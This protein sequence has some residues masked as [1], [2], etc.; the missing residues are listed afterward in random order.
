MTALRSRFRVERLEDRALPSAANY[1]PPSNFRV[2]SGLAAVDARLSAGA[3]LDIAL[4]YLNEH[5]GEFNATPADLIDP[6]VTGQ[7]TDADSGTTYIYLRQKVNGLEVVNAELSISI[8][9]SG[10]VFTVGG[11]FVAGLD[12]KVDGV[13]GAVMSAEQA[14]LAAA[15]E[16]S[17]PVEDAPTLVNPP[18][19][20]AQSF[21]VSAPSV[22]FHD[23]PAK[24]HYVPTADGGASL[25][26]NLIIETTDSQHWY[27]VSVDARTGSVVH[28]SDWIDHE[29]YHVVPSPND[30]PHDGG[31]QTLVNPQNPTA[32]PFGWHDTNGAVGAEFT[33][34]RG[35][36]VDAHL[37]RDADNVAD[38]NPP[39]PTGGAALD[40]G[41]YWFNATQAPSALANQNAAVV[42]LFHMNNLLHDVHY[43]YGFTEAAGNFQT[44]N[45]GKGGLGNDAVQADAQDGS[46]TNNANF[47]TPTD[48]N[49]P[50]MQMYIWTAANP[51]RDSDLDNGIIAHEY[52]HGVSNRLTGGP[53]NSSALNATQSGGMGEGWSDFHALM[54]AQRATDTKNGAFG[55]GTYVLNQ[56]VNGDGI[57]RFRYSFDMGVNPLTY[58]AYGSSGTTSYGVTRSN[59]VHNT[60][61]I[62]CST[63]W[64]LNWLL[65]DKYGFDPNLGTGWSTAAGPA[66]AGNKLTLKLVMDAM[67]LQP[68]NPSF[69]QARDA[70]IAA[71]IAVNG[72]ADLYEIWLAFARRGLGTNASTAGSSST[73]VS[74][75]FDLPM[76]VASVNPDTGAVVTSSPTGYT[77][78]VTSAINAASLQASDLTVNGQ[79]ATG[80]AYTPG[81]TFAVFT[82]ASD[83]VTAE[84]KQVIAV[85][86]NAF[87]RASDG[88]GVAAFSSSFYLDPTPL[89]V[90]SFTPAPGTT[91]SPPMTTLDINLNGA[92]N[93]ASIQVSDLSLSRGSVTGFSLLNGNTTVRF[94]LANLTTEG[95]VTASLAAGAFSDANG[96]PN[97]AFAG[98]S[99]ILDIGSSPFPVPLTARAPA[100]ALIYEGAGTALIGTAGDSDSLTLDLDAGQTLSV[101]VSPLYTLRPSLTI[102]GPGTNL[103]NTAAA[104]GAEARLLAVPISTAGT[105]TLAV[106][107]A[108]STT[109]NFV[110]RVVL[111]TAIEAESNG[112]P[113]NDTTATAE[114]LASVFVSL[115]PGTA[116][117]SVRGRTD[118][119]T[120]G[121]VE[122]N[123]TI[124]TAQAI[125]S[126]TQ[127]PGNLYQMS[128]SGA[129][130]GSDADYFNIGTMQVG[131]VITITES[132]VGSGLGTLTDARIR[133]YR[134]NGGSPVQVATDDDGGPGTD[135]LVYRFTVTTSDTYFARA[136]RFSTNDSG[137]YALNLFLE[138]TSTPPL[139][140]GIFTTEVEPNE[141][142]GGANNAA[143]AWRPINY[144]TTIG[145]QITAGDTDLASFTF[146]AGEVVSF[147]TR[148]TSGL[149]PQTALLDSSGTVV[150]TEDGTSSVAGAGGLSPIYAYIIPADG[151]YYFR[152][153]AIGG[154]TGSYQADVYLTTAAT[155]P[156]APPAKDLFAFT[157]AANESVSAVIDGLSAGNVDI[158]LL[159]G[160]GTVVATGTTGP[161]NVDEIV[162]N[163]AAPAAGTYYLQVSGTPNVD[164]QATVVR[165]GT[166]D[167]EANDSFA[168][169]QPLGGGRSALGTIAGNDDWY[170]VALT[171][172]NTITVS[173]ATPGGG[174]GEFV[175]LLDPLVELYDPSNTLVGADDNS[176]VD[177]K[178]ARLTR[179]A[180]VSGNYRIRVSKAGATAGEYVLS[181]AVVTAVPP[182][183]AGF[184][185]ND[186]SPQRSRVTSLTV[187]FDS[188]VTLPV[189]PSDAFA[190]VRQGG[191][192]VS[193][194]AVAANS[195]NT[196]VTITFTGGSVDANSLADGLFTLTVNAALV[197]GAGGP[198]DGDGNGTGGDDYV[199]VGTPANGLYRLFGDSDGDGDVDAQDFGAFRGAFGTVNATFD[200]DNDADVDAAD[201]GAFRARFGTSV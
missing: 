176:D 136:S 82:F 27:D 137:T 191:G 84:G 98:G 183:V 55:I 99:Y 10:A 111:N 151:T 86:G 132:G 161:T 107:G 134:N 156:V 23:I 149:S 37:D 61:E 197:T 113:P 9:A 30:A 166:F 129:L 167:A 56:S 45:Y 172:G 19:G 165:G 90:V 97:A 199:V 89:S 67:K 178:N 8:L 92:V 123:N 76:V 147:V 46:G 200:F 112:V 43:Q 127:T 47:G 66:N 201:F 42:N 50:R 49:A 158:A 33:D 101:F 39:R 80:V 54:F 36:N 126:A 35:N 94:N 109:G 182:R 79:P 196:S 195:P 192:S 81:N 108:G 181:A 159:D 38:A 1:L 70:I 140:G 177:G 148:S 29:H 52:G 65:I 131:D 68:A 59:Q 116:A 85:A 20:P 63:L 18:A 125:T 3:P 162:A 51:D 17:L 78:N 72:G 41:G 150:V 34:T 58:D 142:T 75:G 83:P 88:S 13:R 175:N 71:N 139:T 163:F 118:V 11:G 4:A 122:P 145:G 124:G 6:V 143:N 73:S 189:N 130:S 160:G 103:T 40:F 121:E 144:L 119:V 16:L 190:L 32:S 44:N 91:L 7:Y 24:L 102:T 74:A 60:G 168:A 128:I 53:G 105:Y 157:L 14:V 62:W 104:T 15:A 180:A 171:A 133:L 198:L 12:A 117:A 26:W 64:D 185:V 95:P 188:V 187:N 87:T 155:L 110:A 135:S 141:T 2:N 114:N 138:N 106:T 5:A 169:A 154:T 120:V 96:S 100:G 115:T 174:P 164:Y 184:V 186:G 153:S 57:R 25:A 194:S 193:L 152:T 173:T 146:L 77:V 179:T 48:G 93:P 22:S 31:F 170:S 21:Q 69:T 28:L